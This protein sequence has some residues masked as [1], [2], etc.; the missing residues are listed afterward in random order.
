MPTRRKAL[1]EKLTEIEEQITQVKSKSGQDPIN[2]P[3]MIDNQLTT[4]YSYVVM[5][6]YPPTAGA[7]ERFDDLK[8]DLASL[9][10]QFDEVV[11]GDLMAFNQLVAGLNLPPVILAG[12][13]ATEDR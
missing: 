2:F 11:A 7:Y 9:K 4:L 12:T 1:D 5:A 10:A 13:P 3:P 6:D 8:P